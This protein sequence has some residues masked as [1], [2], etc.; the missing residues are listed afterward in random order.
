M[1]SAV[2]TCCTIT[3]GL[4]GDVGVGTAVGVEVDT[5]VGVGDGVGITVGVGVGIWVGVDEGLNVGVGDGVGVGTEEVDLTCADCAS[6]VKVKLA[7][8]EPRDSMASIVCVP[9]S[10]LV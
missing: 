10:Q 3:V 4:G 5:A 1:L 2:H 6:K 9:R 7:E 8:R